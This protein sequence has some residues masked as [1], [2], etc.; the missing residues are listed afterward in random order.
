[1]LIIISPAK[2]LNYK[3]EVPAHDFTIPQHLEKSTELIQQL[4][5]LSV[6]DIANLMKLS[7]N[8]ALLNKERFM[9]WQI[10][11]QIDETTR[12]ALFAFT[13]DVYQGWNPTDRSEKSLLYAQDHVRILS[14]LYGLLRPFDLMKPYRLEMGSK[15]GIQGKKNL[16]EVWTE[17]ITQGLNDQLKELGSTHLVNLASNEYF[18]A[19]D[20]KSLNADII[21]PVFKEYKNGSY[22]IVSFFAKKA[23]GM[24]TQFITENQ[25]SDPE[26]LKLFEMDGYY[27]NDGLSKKNNPVFTRG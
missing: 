2:K 27:Y 4:R 7:D 21:T 13:G 6:Q 5:K 25:I 12:Q 11:E 18:K 10:P 3:A 17:I 19:V 1:M 26:Q 9:N 22:R 14:G 20:K 16:Y 23:R 8:L 24:M 15:F